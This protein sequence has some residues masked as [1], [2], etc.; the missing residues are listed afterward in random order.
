MASI[1]YGTQLADPA[2]NLIEVLLRHPGR[3]S[4]AR[5]CPDPLSLIR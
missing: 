2:G 4:H 1:D 5:P 3:P